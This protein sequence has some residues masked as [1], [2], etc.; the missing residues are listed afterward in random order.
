[1]KRATSVLSVAL[2]MAACIRIDGTH[3]KTHREPAVRPIPELAAAYAYPKTAPRILF[4]E[5]TLFPSRAYRHFSFQ[6]PSLG[7]N[8]QRNNMVRGEYFAAKTSE[9]K[10]LIIVLPIYGT[11]AFPPENTAYNISVRDGWRDTNVFLLSGD[12]ELFD[13]PLLQRVQTEKDFS[14]EMS[15][16]R[17]RFR[18][19]VTDIR[20]LV[21]WASCQPDI[22]TRRIGIVGFSIGAI[23][24]ALTMGVDER[25]SAGAFIMGGGNFHEIFAVSKAHEVENT[26]TLLL[27]ALRWTPDKLKHRLEQEL[28][29]INPVYAVGAVNP[30]RVLLIDSRDDHFIPHSAQ[31]ALWNAFGRPTRKTLAY[32]HRMAFVS[33][34]IF[35]LHYTDYA[36]VGFFR[37]TL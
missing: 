4:S 2:I 34:T 5:D 10:K 16:T 18:N 37:N 21:D 3:L 29:T 9:K 30:A 36:I 35:G 27:R 13:W 24:G 23:I 15:R 7:E 12:E 33:M 25:I 17:L 31:D 8:G 6:F 14:Q 20:R 28:H 32:D 19:T 26:R 11:P 1:M 22:D